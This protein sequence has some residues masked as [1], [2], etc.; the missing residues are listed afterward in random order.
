MEQDHVLTKLIQIT[1]T[2]FFKLTEI[3]FMLVLKGGP[4]EGSY[5]L[6]QFH[7]HWG[8]N[9]DNGSEHTING[10]SYPAEVS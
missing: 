5:E 3:L 2:N 7:A 8:S 9:N 6:W 10:R 1:K 4:L